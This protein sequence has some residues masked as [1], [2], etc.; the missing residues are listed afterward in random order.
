MQHIFFGQNG[1]QNVN[2]LNLTIEVE[3]LLNSVNQGYQKRNYQDDNIPDCRAPA[4][5]L[6]VL[7]VGNQKKVKRP[8]R[9]ER[10][11]R[12]MDQIPEQKGNSDQATG[13]Y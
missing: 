10:I 6:L 8:Q 2:S 1:F 13:G 4:S 9:H 7:A 12:F 3:K 11:D 5:G